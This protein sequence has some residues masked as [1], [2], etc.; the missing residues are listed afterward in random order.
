MET[1]VDDG[2]AT[3]SVRDRGI[4]PVEARIRGDTKL[5]RTQLGDAAAIEANAADIEGVDDSS[6]LSIYVEDETTTS[7][8][9]GLV[10]LSLLPS[11]R[12]HVLLDIW[13]NKS[14]GFLKC[15]C[16]GSQ[17]LVWET[18]QGHPEKE[19]V[20]RYTTKKNAPPVHEMAFYLGSVRFLDVIEPHNPIHAEGNITPENAII[21]ADV[22]IALLSGVEDEI[23][24]MVTAMIA[25]SDEATTSTVVGHG[26]EVEKDL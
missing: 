1:S 8:P 14:R 17:V 23:E 19:M 20:L 18:I 5:R 6:G 2:G 22:I 12:H 25:H 15:I 16:H 13:R 7:F 4:L 3:S 9:G 11:F 10:N 26:S 21:M 24:E